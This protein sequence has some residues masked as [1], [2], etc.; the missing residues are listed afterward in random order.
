MTQTPER[1]DTRVPPAAEPDRLGRI[2]TAPSGNPRSWWR[3]PYPWLVL[4]A[5]AIVVNLHHAFPQYLSTDSSH[6]RIMLRPGFSLHYPVLL[7][8]V[9]TGNIAMV[10][11]FLQ[12]WPWLR[13]Q[14]PAVHRASGRV[15]IF[16]GALPAA[17][18]GLVLVPLR[19]MSAGSIG[20]ATMAV[21]WLATTLI[22]L[23]AARL[24]RYA[25]HR[26][27]MVYSFALALGTTWGR[28]LFLMFTHITGFTLSDAIVIDLANWMGWVFNLLV[29]HVW[30]EWTANRSSR[31]GTQTITYP[32]PR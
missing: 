1:S 8:H 32:A 25:E 12:F 19:P 22:A 11:L 13:R 10:T 17:L 2:S 6:A 4:L 30:L 5:A 9:F 27:F 24:G 31:A 29:A 28:I 26:R 7:V 15:Y 18:M 21:L 14:H 20:L 16:A 3:Q 23:R